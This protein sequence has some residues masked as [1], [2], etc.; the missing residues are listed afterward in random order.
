MSDL[1][2][3]VDLGYTAFAG[4]DTSPSGIQHGP[5]VFFG[6]IPYA[7]PPVHALRWRAPQLLDE[8][9]VTSEI[10]DARNWGPPCLQVPAMV[11][12][13]S[14]DCLTL[15]V[16]KPRNASKGDELP[17]AVYIHS[18][19]GFPLYDW[20]EQHHSG[21][22]GVS[23]AYRL[24]I[25]GFLGG[26]LIAAD[27]DL[28]VGLLDQRAA[29]EWIKRNVHNFGG[30]PDSV[31]IYGES[32]GGASVMMQITAYG[33]TR[34]L[35]FKRAVAQSIAFGPTRTDV[36]VEQSF[37][38]VAQLV[39]CPSH[40]TD[41]LKCL[42]NA[43]LGAIVSASNRL[44]STE[45][46]QFAPVVEGPAGF[47]PGLPTRLIASGKFIPVEYI[48]GHCTGDGRTFTL[49]QPS[50]FQTDEDIKKLLLYWWPALSN[51][52]L[53]KTLKLY[54][55][56]DVPGSPFS[57]QWNRVSTIARD[58]DFWCL[59]WFLAEKLADHGVDNVYSY[60]WDAPDTVLYEAQPY[61]GA[62]HTSDVYYLFSGTNTFGNAGNTFNPFNASEAILSKEAI[63]YWT[64]FASTGDP[65]SFK[66]TASASWEKYVVRNRTRQRMVFIRG[67][68][69][70]TAS[71]MKTITSVEIDRCKFWMSEDT[72]AELRI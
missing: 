59:N 41:A 54:P 49:G 40:G 35:P 30:N 3:V 18:P 62:M 17:V 26:H 50:D 72:I 12:V 55:S 5:V 43:S 11:G 60:A 51:A 66:G 32:A 34:A 1:G 63:A 48:G 65:S 29:L 44:P 19:Q 16:W 23:I 68:D 52:T 24:G 37:S 58:I 4:N 39:G 56:P 33:G 10:V 38:N 28:N 45:P 20:V 13:G 53:Y 36:E 70:M 67:D 8:S 27:G 22:V 6:G 15:N 69:T 21:L 57:T 71:R 9:I 47:M 2:P 25:L 31:T 64:T 7:Q 61:L 46:S 42:R 14:E